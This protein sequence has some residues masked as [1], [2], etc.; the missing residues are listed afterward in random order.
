MLRSVFINEKITIEGIQ[1]NW[2][3]TKLLLNNQL[4]WSTLDEVKLP[5]EFFL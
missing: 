1:S 4:H 5:I 3:Q 2:N